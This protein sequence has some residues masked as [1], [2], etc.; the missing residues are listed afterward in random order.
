MH[1]HRRRGMAEPPL[2]IFE[3]IDPELLKLVQMDVPCKNKRDR[4]LT[5]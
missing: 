4:P 2:K 5:I 1:F 3:R